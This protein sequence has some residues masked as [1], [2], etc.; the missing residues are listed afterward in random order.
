M[1]ILLYFFARY[2]LAP[3]FVAVMI[4]VLTGIKTIKSKLSLKKLIIFILLASIAVALPSLFGFLKNEYVWGGLTFT[5]LSY[6]LLG[7]LFCKLSTSDLFGAI[8]IGS[9]RTAVILT[10]TTIC[11]LGGWCYYLLF[12][13]ISKL[14]YSLWNTTNILWFAIPYLIMYSRTL[15]LDIPHPIY[16]PWELSYGT[17]DRKYWD[18]IDNFGFRTVK[19]KI[20]RNIKDPRVARRVRSD[21]SFRL[22][23]TRPLHR[24]AGAARRSGDQPAAMAHPA[25]RPTRRSHAAVLAQT[26]LKNRSGRALLSPITSDPVSAADRPSSNGRRC[27]DRL[28]TDAPRAAEQRTNRRENRAIRKKCLPLRLVLQDS[29]PEGFVSG[30]R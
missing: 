3:L 13:L 2:L 12:E 8:G 5:I 4:F 6:I 22:R 25:R 29:T 27:Y 28:R 18:N 19:V 14:P 7:A 1:K 10:L 21:G 30:V 20:K 17:F 15:F 16:T 24:C 9:S 23:E 26:R 11:A